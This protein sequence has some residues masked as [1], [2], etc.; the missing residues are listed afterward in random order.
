MA[1]RKLGRGLDALLG[2]ARATDGEE[3]V[4][5]PL[6]QVSSGPFQPRQGFAESRLRELANSIREN[7]VLQP[8]IVRPGGVGYEI[9]AGERRAR[10][11][12]LAGLPEIPAIVRSYGDD[13]MLVLSLVENVQRRDLN[14]I[15]KALAYRR[16]VAH[17]EATQE[18]VAK[19]LGLDRS[20]VANMIR[21]L[22]LPVEIRDLVRSGALAM[23]HARAILGL[24][25][26][27]AQ[28][29]MA[30]RV[31][32][33]DLSVRAVEQFVRGGRPAA[34]PRRRVSPRKTAQVMALEDELRGLLGT[35]VRIKDRRGKGRIEIDYYSV[36]E[37]DRILEL[38]RRTE[39][40]FGRPAPE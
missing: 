12:R 11:A 15:D 19:R 33:E 10:A 29:D 16:L 7:G 35:K 21:L 14:P 38:L 39:S 4:R 31:I 40:G 13:E 34:S 9:V 37:F 5:L 28:I 26:K 1:E 32:R 25:G 36:S 18:D 8:I 27:A 20:S 6:D 23:G 17:L 2:E 22:D 30:K 24:A 3:I